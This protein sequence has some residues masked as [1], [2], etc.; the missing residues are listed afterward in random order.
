MTTGECVHFSSA[1]AGKDLSAR[2][3]SAFNTGFSRAEF[4][5]AQRDFPALTY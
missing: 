5:Q 4:A 3:A 1:A 2:A